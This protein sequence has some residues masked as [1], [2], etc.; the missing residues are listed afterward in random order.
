MDIKSAFDDSERL[1]GALLRIIDLPTID[2]DRVRISDTACSLALEHWHSVRALLEMA[3]LPSAIVVHRAQFEALL[4]S[5]WL[6][7][8]AREEDLAKLTAILDL[9]SEQAAKNMPTVNEMMEHVQKKAPAPAYA[10]LNRFKQHSWKALNSYAH[11]GIHPLRRHAEG[12][13]T[14]LIHSV[15]CNANGLGVIACMQAVVL[16]DKQPLQRQVL[17]IAA[18]YP[19]CMPQLLQN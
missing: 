14:A 5:V 19:G 13:P 18:N 12:S 6:T 3:L 17:A 9:E 16:S 11:A 2:S 1:V 8:A 7:Y 15:L 10:A 4:R